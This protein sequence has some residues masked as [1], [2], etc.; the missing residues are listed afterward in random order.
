MHQ[1][2]IDPTPRI[3]AM[4]LLLR[5]AGWTD[6]AYRLLPAIAPRGTRQSLRRKWPTLGLSGVRTSNP[7][8]VEGRL[9]A[10]IACW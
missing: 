2:R 5:R 6:R 10:Q 3:A 7:T 9:N 1:S 8:H 4:K